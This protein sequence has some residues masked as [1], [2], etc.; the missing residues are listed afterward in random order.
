MS[1]WT[2]TMVLG[3]ATPPAGQ[4]QPQQGGGML[5]IGYM[6]IIFALFY[7]MMIRPQMKKE[8]ERKKLIE[9]VKSGDRVMFCGGMIGTVANVK[10]TIF[11]VKVADNVKIEVARG[12][13]LRVLDKDEVPGDVD[14]NA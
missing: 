9:S 11:S 6:A 1:V 2:M 4:G 8:K 14:K 12:A 7:F 13:I 5:M 3:M 10:D